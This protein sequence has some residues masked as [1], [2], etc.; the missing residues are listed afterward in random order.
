M[1]WGYPEL[2]LETFLMQFEPG[3]LD[4]S[5]GID[6]MSGEGFSIDTLMQELSQQAA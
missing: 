6:P 1:L 4:V 2:A 3:A 5:P